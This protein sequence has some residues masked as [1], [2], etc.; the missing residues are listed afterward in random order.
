MGSRTKALIIGGVAGAAVGVAAAWLFIRSVEEEALT[1]EEAGEGVV[2]PRT[3][4]VGQVVRLGVSILGV[5][6]QIVDLGREE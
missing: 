6:R 5:L 1:V 2:A 3:I 4:G